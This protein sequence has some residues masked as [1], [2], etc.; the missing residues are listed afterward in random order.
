MVEYSTPFR[1]KQILI[2]KYCMMDRKST[3]FLH[4]LTQWL[5]Y[6]TDRNVSHISTLNVPIYKL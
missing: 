1:K 3:T 4:K 6:L 2:L 5:F